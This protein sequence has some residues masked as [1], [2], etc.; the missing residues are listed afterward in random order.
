MSSQYGDVGLLTADIGWLIW[1]TLANFTGFRVLASLLHRST[2]VNQ[3]LDMF[4]RPLGWY[5]IYTF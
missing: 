4:G 1:G 5:T 3:T 2:D